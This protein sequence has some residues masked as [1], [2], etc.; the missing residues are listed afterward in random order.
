MDTF[1]FPCL[2]L[3]P[4]QAQ[5]APRIT[6]PCTTPCPTFPQVFSQ[7]TNPCGSG[8]TPLV[9]IMPPST[10]DTSPCCPDTCDP[11]LR[12]YSRTYLNQTADLP[13]QTAFIV[14]SDGMYQIDAGLVVKVTDSGGGTLVFAVTF[15][16]LPSA[17]GLATPVTGSQVSSTLGGAEDGSVVQGLMAYLLKGT[18]VNISVTGGSYA[19]GGVYDAWFSMK[20]LTP[21]ASY[22]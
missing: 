10:Q 17:P 11:P 19:A 22:A 5:C 7:N 3:N 1:N 21:V 2:P 13:A 18:P 8:G 14:P 20:R 6:P 12:D 15:T 4:C 9:F 16:T